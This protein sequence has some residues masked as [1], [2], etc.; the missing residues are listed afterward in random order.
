MEARNQAMT[1]QQARGMSYGTRAEFTEQL[2][3]NFN[4]GERAVSR[5]SGVSK[6][7]LN[8]GMPHEPNGSRNGESVIRRIVALI[9]KRKLYQAAEWNDTVARG[10]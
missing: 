7:H 3:I 8:T 10:K 4:Q 9:N 6:G 1:R 5:A 2:T